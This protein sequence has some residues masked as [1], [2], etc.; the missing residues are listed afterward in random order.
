MDT[1]RAELSAHCARTDTCHRDRLRSGYA[2]ARLPKIV[3][4]SLKRHPLS[5]RKNATRQSVEDAQNPRGEFC[6]LSNGTRGI[7]K[8]HP[9]TH[10]PREP[11]DDLDTGTPRRML[12]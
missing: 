10:P 12:Q 3:F 5:V 6:A 11:L 1:Y 7:Y 4:M 2:L 9:T 8:S